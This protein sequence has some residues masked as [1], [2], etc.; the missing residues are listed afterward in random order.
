MTDDLQQ[1]RVEAA[2]KA[3]LREW[4]NRGSAL[5]GEALRWEFKADARAALAAADAHF[6][7]VEAIAEVLVAHRLIEGSDFAGR[8][9]GDWW[10]ACR[11]RESRSGH[12]AHQAEA[13][14][15]LFGEV[16]VLVTPI[17][18]KEHEAKHGSEAQSV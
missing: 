8:L 2:A 11:W 9:N 1:A 5:S 7:S 15:A 12:L 14:R 18:V 13:V 6:P 16:A 10:C 17:S 3:I 4:Q